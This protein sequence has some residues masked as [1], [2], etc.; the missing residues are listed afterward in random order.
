MPDELTTTPEHVELI[1]RL[2]ELNPEACRLEPRSIY[3]A[4]IIGITDNPKDQWPRE[5]GVYVAVYGAEKCIAAA[6]EASDGGSYDEALD[7]FH[8][9]TSGGYYGPGTPTFVWEEGEE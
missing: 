6:V 7:S 4:C 8:Y 2:A 5:P 9:N 1:R 3:D